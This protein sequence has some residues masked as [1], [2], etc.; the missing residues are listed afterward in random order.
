[1][2]TRKKYFM[3]CHLAGRKYHDAD[4][5]WEQLRVGTVLRL[6]RDRDNRYDPEAVAVMYY[7]PESDQA[8]CLGYIPRSS[9]T[10]LAILLDMGWDEI[11]E[12]R[13]SRL[14]ADGNPEQQVQLTIRIVRNPA[15]P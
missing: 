15:T 7:A 11:F 5:V 8:Y 4:E 13:I 1:M 12:C 10:T 2:E 6:V 9:N 3:D 14:V